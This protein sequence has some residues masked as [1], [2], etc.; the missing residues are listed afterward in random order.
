ME[1]FL[2][3]G[4]VRDKLLNYPIYDR[5]WVVTGATPNDMLALGY[6][7]VGSDFPVFLHPQTQEEYALART[8]RKSGKGYKGFLYHTSP[9]V[10]LEEDLYRRDLTINAMAESTSGQ[11]ID[12]YGGQQDIERRIL[13]HVSPAFVEDPLRV[14]RVAR[15]AARYAHL[16]F[17]IAPETT[18]LMTEIAISGELEY[19][20]KERIWQELERALGERSPLVFF[21]VLSFTQATERLFPELEQI[22]EHSG[23]RILTEH[24]GENAQTPVRFATLIYFCFASQ[25][26]AATKAREFC[27]SLKAPNLYRDLLG[28]LL[29]ALPALQ[30]WPQLSAKER[31]GTIKRLDL[32]RRNERLEPLVKAC[33]LMTLAGFSLALSP[34]TL[35]TLV[36]ELKTIQ[37]AV[38]IEQGFKGAQ[39]GAEIERQQ[40]AIC[41]SS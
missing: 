4:A 37:P 38:L 29:T 32:L 9:D 26:D 34:D 30:N 21:Q 8:E 5:D 22:T 2:V 24:F 35:A 16:G 10:T 25:P 17:H 14:L 33:S 40:E 19:L 20:T 31:L 18:A 15:F 27:T 36:K 11:L 28:Q 12:P 3:G 13:R 6:R 41:Q 23:A 39:L 1:I 7:P